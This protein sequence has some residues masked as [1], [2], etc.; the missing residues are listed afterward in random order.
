MKG[1]INT[2]YTM[3]KLAEELNISRENLYYLLNKEEEITT[4]L[5]TFLIFQ[6]HR[7]LKFSSI[8]K[9]FKEEQIDLNLKIEE[10]DFIKHYILERY[11]EEI[12]KGYAFIKS[13]KISYK[14]LN[15]YIEELNLLINIKEKRFKLINFIENDK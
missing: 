14:H 12:R 5:L 4:C 2:Y 15:K 1:R 11:E 8:S 9:F 6:K 10:F 3:E 13:Y 7:D